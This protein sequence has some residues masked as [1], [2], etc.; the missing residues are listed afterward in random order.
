MTLVGSSTSTDVEK[1]KTTKREERGEDDKI[2]FQKRYK[3]AANES[4]LHPHQASFAD[5]SFLETKIASQQKTRYDASKTKHQTESPLLQLRVSVAC[6]QTKP[7]GAHATA[8]LGKS[9]NH[10]HQGRKH[11]RENCITFSTA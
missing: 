6:F 3:T 1:K 7:D 10:H 8:N 9:T 5:A 4:H 11:N 2:T